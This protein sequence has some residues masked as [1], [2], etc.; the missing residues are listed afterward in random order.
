MHWSHAK[1][2]GAFFPARELMITP[3]LTTDILLG[4]GL[5]ALLLPAAYNPQL[6]CRAGLEDLSAHLTNTCRL[7]HSAA[8]AS[9]SAADDARERQTVMLLSELPL[10]RS[11]HGPFLGHCSEL[12]TN[13]LLD[14]LRG[15]SLPARCL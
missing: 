2:T 12:P 13:Q 6:F 14:R 8:A 10:V 5:R 3:V 11:C 9:K 1:R 15:Q 7:Q 4:Q